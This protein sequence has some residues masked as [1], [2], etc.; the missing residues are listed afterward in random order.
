MN[1]TFVITFKQLQPK[2]FLGMK[3]VSEFFGIPE[4]V[5]EFFRSKLSVS[6]FLGIGIGN[7]NFR[8][9]SE[10]V[11]TFTD[12]F[13]RFPFW[14]GIYR[15]HNSVFTENINQPNPSSKFTAHGPLG[16]SPP[17]A[18]LPHQQFSTSAHHSPAPPLPVPVSPYAARF[19]RPRMPVRLSGCP[20]L[21][22]VPSR[23]SRQPATTLVFWFSAQP[24]SRQPPLRR[25]SGQ[26][27][28]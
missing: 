23:F 9:E 28:A 15:I 22:L 12:R 20:P 25:A 3:M 24:V 2:L 27:D 7:R 14:V 6:V 17:R 5:F 16:S 26:I 21:L 13:L 8:S 11:Q 19:S 10:S 18:S 4:T 1:D